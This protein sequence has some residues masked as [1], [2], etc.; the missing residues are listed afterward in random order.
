M[1]GTVILK[2]AAIGSSGM[3]LAEFFIIDGNENDTFEI[4]RLVS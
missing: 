3:G 1:R 4:L 2:V